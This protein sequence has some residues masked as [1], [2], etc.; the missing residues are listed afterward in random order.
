[1]NNVKL[2]GVIGTIE[3]RANNVSSISVG[4][5]FPY[6]DKSTG[7]TKF[8]T[9]WHRVIAFNR[10]SDKLKALQAEKTSRISVEGSLRLNVWQDKEGKEHK[11][12]EIVA[13]DI[14]LLVKPKS[15]E[16]KVVNQVQDAVPTQQQYEGDNHYG[17]Y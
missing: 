11:N 10:L 8:R 13:S 7:T 14:E 9:E 2:K 16:Q 12:T 15:Q 17:Y 4:T 3:H 6:K 5:S 1:M